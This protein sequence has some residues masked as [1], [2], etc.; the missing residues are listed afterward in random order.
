M[1]ERMQICSVR[2]QKVKIHSGCQNGGAE[3]SQG[4]TY[5]DAFCVIQKRS[6]VKY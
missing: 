5:P 3:K 1:F 2:R 4:K 6:E